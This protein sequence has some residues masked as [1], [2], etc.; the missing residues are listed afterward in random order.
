MNHNK[1]KIFVAAL[2]VCLVSVLSFS[3][4]AWFSATE[5]VTNRF[6]VASSSVGGGGFVPPQ[7]PTPPTP[8]GT[9]SVD[10]WEYD[11]SVLPSAVA[12]ADKNRSGM[13]FSNVVPGV[14]YDKH[15]VIENNGDHAQWIRAQVTFSKA[16]VWK[17]AV[18]DLS[19]VFEG[20]D[21][22]IWTFDGQWEDSAANTIT[23]Y[24][25]LNTAL[26]PNEMVTLFT[27][28]KLPG[29]LT[30]ENLT[31]LGGTFDVSIRADAVQSADTGTN[32]KDAFETV[33]NWP[34][35]ST[36]PNA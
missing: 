20:L 12:E 36:I 26:A 14:T 6:M 22:T 5:S 4:L 27:D 8:S 19:V 25:Y 10:L 21:S 29:S 13:S 31:D 15:S 2:A 17:T 18:P 23:Y 11:G 32:A 7:P 1:K 34:A 33:V 28:V 9:F 16:Q 24:Y 3:T 30:Q 35:N